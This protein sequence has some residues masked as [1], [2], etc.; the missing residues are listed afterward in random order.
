MTTVKD[1]KEWLNNFPEDTIVQFAVQ[2]P[3][4]AYESYGELKYIEPELTNENLSCG[5][6]WD[7]VDFTNN[8]FV[9]EGDPHFG[10]KFLAFG[11]RN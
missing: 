1:L 8:Q 4:G 3:G 7:F 2:Q 10:K 5:D 6:G 11:E 9:K